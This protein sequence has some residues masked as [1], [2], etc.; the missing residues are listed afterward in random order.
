MGKDVLSQRQLLVFL[1]TAMLA[2]LAGSLPGQIAS[3][4]GEGAWAAPLV[5]L[6]VILL[7]CY[8]LKV[9]FPAKEKNQNLMQLYQAVLGNWLGGAVILAYLAWGLFLLMVNTRLYGERLLSAGYQKASLAL[10]LALLLVL[11]LWMARGKISAFLRAVEIF[12][13]LLTVALGAALLFALFQIKVEYILP[14]WWEDLPKILIGTV[15]VLGLISYGIFGT[16]FLDQLPMG[17][18]GVRPAAMKWSGAVC[19]V[20][21]LLQLAVVGQF[22][23]TLCAQMEEPFLQMVAGIGVQGAFQRLEGVSAALWIL[24][25]LALLGLLTFACKKMGR[26]LLPSS[27][28]DG[29]LPVVIVLFALMGAL[30][31]LPDAFSAQNAARMILPIGNFIAAFLLPALLLLIGKLRKRL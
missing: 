26:A 2:P 1:F 25:D 13:L 12:Y 29:W 3:L 30:N 16:C 27:W 6:P 14:L 8:M 10:V 19:L 4:A 11:V 22:G 7:W 24:A 28:K 21:C 18:G 20:L 23:A 17:E 5:A 31:L 15:P 9:L